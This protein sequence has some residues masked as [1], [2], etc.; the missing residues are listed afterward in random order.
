MIEG[1]AQREDLPN[2]HAGRGRRGPEGRD[3]SGIGKGRRTQSQRFG[4]RLVLRGAQVVHAGGAVGLAIVVDIEN[5]LIEIGGPVGHILGRHNFAV[6]L[7]D[8]EIV[9]VIADVLN[10]DGGE[11]A[12][13]VFFHDHVAVRIPGCVG[14][15]QLGQPFIAAIQARGAGEGAFAGEK[16][17]DSSEESYRDG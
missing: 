6:L 8:P 9:V 16:V 15:G 10:G 4:G 5:V 2:R 14:A 3:C 17:R 7:R 12:R 1:R 13:V 11:D